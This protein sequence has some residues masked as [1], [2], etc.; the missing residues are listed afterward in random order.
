MFNNANVSAYKSATSRAKTSAACVRVLETLAH[1]PALAQ[2]SPA[3]M[4]LLE[5]AHLEFLVV[6]ATLSGL[7]VEVGHWA[8]QSG[9]LA[10]L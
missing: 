10:A 6:G 5:R 9:A 3:R 7:A 4:V 8:M 2:R 1:W